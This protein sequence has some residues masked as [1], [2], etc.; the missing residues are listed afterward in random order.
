MLHESN[1][2]IAPLSMRPV[3][4]NC[5]CVPVRSSRP[6]KSEYIHIFK[7][8]HKIKTH[9]ERPACP[10]RQYRNSDIPNKIHLLSNHISNL[11]TPTGVRFRRNIKHTEGDVTVLHEPQII[12]LINLTACHR[13]FSD[14]EFLRHCVRLPLPKTYSGMS[15]MEEDAEGIEKEV[16]NRVGDRLLTDEEVDDIREKVVEEH[17]QEERKKKREAFRVEQRLETEIEEKKRKDREEARKNR[18]KK[19]G[20]PVMQKYIG[21]YVPDFNKTNTESL[22]A[23]HVPKGIYLET[24]FQGDRIVIHVRFDGEE[25]AEDA[26]SAFPP[27]SRIWVKHGDPIRE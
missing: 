11:L 1:R 20:R 14:Q 6:T 9:I 17:I 13:Q 27:T 18:Q 23:N 16:R 24:T 12:R 26:I 2:M 22:L 3:T 4:S 10:H 15:I 8:T 7:E 21:N 19:R 5:Y 25:D